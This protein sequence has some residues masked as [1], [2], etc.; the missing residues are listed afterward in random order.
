MDDDDLYE[1]V[2]N[3]VPESVDRQSALISLN[4]GEP[5]VAVF[6]LIEE[7]AAVGKLAP[8]VVSKVRETQ[9]DDDYRE[10]LD[11]IADFAA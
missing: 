7:A 10:L 6:A 5:R 9:P 1:W 4:A 2:D 8:V 11:A 3:Q